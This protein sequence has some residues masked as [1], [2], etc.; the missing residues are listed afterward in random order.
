[1]SQTKQIGLQANAVDRQAL[2]AVFKAHHLEVAEASRAIGL[3]RRRLGYGPQDHPKIVPESLVQARRKADLVRM[4]MSRAILNA[5]PVPIAEMTTDDIV[6]L[7][8][9]TPRVTVAAI[10][11][12]QE[13]NRRGVCGFIRSDFESSVICWCREHHHGP[14]HGYDPKYANGCRMQWDAIFHKQ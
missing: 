14:N 5:L 10:E 1:M 11:C 4:M 6:W 8:R 7:A 3:E 13:L 9:S 12:L 2:S